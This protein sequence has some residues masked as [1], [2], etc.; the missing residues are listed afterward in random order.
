MHRQKNVKKVIKFVSYSVTFIIFIYLFENASSEIT[1]SQKYSIWWFEQQNPLS[2]TLEML[3]WKAK[4]KYE[5]VS[6]NH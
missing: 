4:R 1:A 3:L 5:M 2:S 6:F